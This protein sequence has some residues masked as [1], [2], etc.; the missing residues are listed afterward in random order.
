MN[1]TAAAVEANVTVATIR[2]WARNGVVAATKVA[3]QWIIDTVSLA[4]RIA[5]GAWKRTPAYTIYYTACRH[6]ETSH[7][8]RRDMISVAICTACHAASKERAAKAA[9]IEAAGGRA[10]AR[11]ISYLAALTGKPASALQ[12]LTKPE[13]SRLIDQAK[14]GGNGRR[15][16]RCDCPSG[17]YG[18]V[19]TCC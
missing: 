18:G 2:E 17:R 15:S 16:Y 13:A 14:R 12:D 5:I 9:A 19:C 8:I 10:T 1:T 6:T 4:R 11:Q 3:G 7:G